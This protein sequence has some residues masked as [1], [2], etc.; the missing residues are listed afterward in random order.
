[1]PSPVVSIFASSDYD[2]QISRGAQLLREGGLVVLPTESAYGTAGLLTHALGRERLAAYRG[3]NSRPFTLHLANPEDAGQYLGDVGDYGRRLIR[4]LW[5]GPVSLVFSVPAE[6]RAKVAQTLSLAE[7]S[8]YDADGGITLRCPKH[9]VFSDVVSQVP[10]PVAL[11]LA[12]SSASGPHWSA[13]A[14]AQEL[15]ERVD[16]IFDAGPTDY[17]KPSTIL[18]VSS[19]H[20][21]IVRPGI[22]DER[23]I[24]RL[25][26]TTILFVCSGN[27]CRS[28][29]AEAIARNLL[30]KRLGIAEAELDKKGIGVMSAGC[31]AMPARG[32]RRKRSRRFGNWERT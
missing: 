15:G 30:A 19:D 26:R 4:K 10:G 17:S 32:R 21:E 1:M 14:L 31:F 23:I 29:M 8:L 25:L 28:P 6:Q 9:R 5:P 22:Y 11:T 2:A 16:L 24:D 13:P 27:T 18:K 7:S 12:G 20:Y 3:D